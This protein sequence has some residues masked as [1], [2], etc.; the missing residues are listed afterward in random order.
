[1]S[2][3]L[4]VFLLLTLVS[5][6]TLKIY[7]SDYI[8][9]SCNSEIWKLGSFCMPKDPEAH[10]PGES[11]E[12]YCRNKNGLATVMGCLAIE[13]FNDDAM[14]EKLV[15]H[16]EEYGLNVTVSDI[17]SAYQTYLLSAEDVA[18]DKTYNLS[19]PVDFPLKLVDT[20]SV[21]ASRDAYHVFFG[22]FNNSLY[23]GAGCL[24]YWALVIL[25]ST[26]FNWGFYIFPRSRNLFNGKIS[27][28]FR[29]YVSTP[30]LFHR[31]KNV[32]QRFL[33][34]FGFLIPT[35]LETIVT[36]G[37]FSLCVILCAVDITYVEGQTIYPTKQIFVTRL[38]ADRTGIICSM[39]TPLFIMFA[40][41]NN[42][43]QF[44][45]G[46]KASTLFV[47]HRWVA[48]IVVLMAFIH[49]ICFTYIYVDEAYYR[50]AMKEAWLRWGVVATTVGGLI[51]F[52]G[53]LVLRR[54][55]YET[56]LLF[57]ILL[58]V[59]WVV[60]MWYHL[61]EMGYQQL[62]Y[63]AMVVWAFDRF[64][65]IV[66]L[67]WF[68]FPQ[69]EVTW[70][71]GDTLKVEV[72]RPKS[73]PCI[74]GG[75]A[76]LHFAH[77]FHFFQSHPFTFI[78]SP[79]KSDTIVFFCKVKG[80]I[81][82]SLVKLLHEKPGKTMHMR[83]SVDGPYG[84]T[85]PVENYSN[86][87]YIAGGSGIS[88]VY[89]EA[90]SMARKVANEIRRVEFV[91]ILQDFAS[92]SGFHD[93][94]NAIRDMGL[95]TTIYIT[96]PE[97]TINPQMYMNRS[98]L[99]SLDEK[100]NME[101]NIRVHEKT[102]VG[103]LNGEYLLLQG[104]SNSVYIPPSSQSSYEDAY[105]LA[106]LKYEYSHVDFHVG[107][108]NLQTI[109]ARQTEQAASSIAFVACGHPVLMDDL[110]HC[111]VEAMGTTQKRVDFYEQLEVWA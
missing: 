58:A 50:T 91:W 57:H 93:E 22:N 61:K 39:L 95:S 105:G 26:A 53:L 1:M 106:G 63:P 47:F 17:K 101:Q 15:V 9:L 6:D 85:S 102:R 103:A 94:I 18:G 67:C 98:N 7:G 5:A 59:F 86:I 34:V 97:T 80:G 13:G 11:Y 56:F 71:L 78:E 51:C 37:F 109:V 44:L 23:F 84:H 72:P 60:G 16:C 104:A 48:R 49:S 28:N 12:C 19:K 89:A 30:A 76:W 54:S 64:F 45:T 87:V 38:I 55:F 69:A 65:R 81:T 20:K 35:R 108:P 4:L 33:W 10:R 83:V 52:Q 90:V 40:G 62:V 99:G 42:L 2:R 79:T 43:L 31:K 82:K 24:A 3:M 74:P 68:G 107:R 77:G 32:S 92:V 36:F 14:H 111:V 66:R 27:R 96:R 41:R 25:I 110:R 70:L 75:H 29:R 100:F 46:W 8:F 88:G 21:R 73:W